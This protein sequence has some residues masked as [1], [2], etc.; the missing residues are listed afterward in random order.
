MRFLSPHLD[1]L[2]FSASF[3]CAVHCIAIPVLLALGSLG[4]VS[5]LHDPILEW[6]LIVFAVVIASWSLFRSY[7]RDHHRRLPLQ[8]AFIGFL[9][10]IAGRFMEGNLEHYVTA[11]AGTLI[12]TAHF[13]NWRFLNT[14][15][16]PTKKMNLG[17]SKAA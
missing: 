5:W 4:S 15:P 16:R 1:F 3:L 12:A 10:I 8:L 2:G 13:F 11:I 6:S 17:R 7:L 9:F 14:C